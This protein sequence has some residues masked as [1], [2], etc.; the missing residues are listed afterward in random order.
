MPRASARS[1]DCLGERV[2]TGA[3]E[4]CGEAKQLVFVMAVTTIGRRDR[5][6]TGPTFG[7]GARLVD[8]ERI[9]PLERF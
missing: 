6:E 2:L 1:D 5:P 3:F 4:A 9:D 8:D 7:E